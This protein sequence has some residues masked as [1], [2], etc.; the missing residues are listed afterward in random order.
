M[1]KGNLSTQ[2][3]VKCYLARIVETNKYPTS[4][5][6]INADA[7]FITAAADSERPADKVRELMHDIPFLVKDEFYMDD[8]HNTFEGTLALLSGRGDGVEQAAQG[9][10]RAAGPLDHV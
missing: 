10:W 1:G 4:I 7:L 2:D 6:N 9:G 3:L 5:S 8:K